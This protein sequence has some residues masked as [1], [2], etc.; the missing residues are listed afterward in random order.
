MN[1]AK[2]SYWEY[3]R[4]APT[5]VYPSGYHEKRAIYRC[6]LCNR[7]F[8]LSVKAEKSNRSLSCLS[9]SR[10]RQNRRTWLL[11][12]LTTGTKIKVVNLSNWCNY[13]GVSFT[14][15]LKTK[16]VS[17]SRKNYARDKRGNRWKI[18]EKIS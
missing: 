11:I 12:N 16:T 1:Q 17:K 6:T 7:E 3:L 2:L 14:T 5:K 15:L 4:E 8:N 10:I 13:Q 18:L 9:C